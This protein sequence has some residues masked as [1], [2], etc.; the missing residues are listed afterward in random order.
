MDDAIL[1][2]EYKMHWVKQLKKPC[3]ILC[4]YDCH[5]GSILEYCSKGP[6]SLSWGDFGL[7]LPHRVKILQKIK[8]GTSHITYHTSHITYYIGICKFYKILVIIIL[9]TFNNS[10]KLILKIFDNF[11]DG[12]NHIDNQGSRKSKIGCELTKIG[13]HVR[14]LRL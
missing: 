5:L 10:S 14:S 8:G 12:N 3:K 4:T 7:P 11:F 6:K 2:F 9:V 13:C 1:L